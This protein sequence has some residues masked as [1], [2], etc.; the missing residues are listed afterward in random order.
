MSHKADET[1]AALISYHQSMLL[2]FMISSYI[3]P[4][5]GNGGGKD[6]LNK[7]YKNL[8]IEY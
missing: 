7:K 4:S 3:Y 5:G 8:C 6:I 1:F 2:K